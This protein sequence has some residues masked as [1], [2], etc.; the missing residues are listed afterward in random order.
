MT[1]F[2]LYESLRELINDDRN[3]EVF[4]NCDKY[5]LENYREDCTN[6]SNIYYDD[7]LKAIVLDK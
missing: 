1:A 4:M 5:L 7:E 6:I 2:E 3:Y